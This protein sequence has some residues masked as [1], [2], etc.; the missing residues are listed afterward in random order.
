MRLEKQSGNLA[1][2]Q[3]WDEGAV[4]VARSGKEGSVVGLVDLHGAFT[5][6]LTVDKSSFSF[7]FS[8]VK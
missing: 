2:S 4:I 5:S 1:G 7:S 8:G 6:Y 3:W